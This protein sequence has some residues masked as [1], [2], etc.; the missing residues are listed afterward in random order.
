MDHTKNLSVPPHYHAEL[1]VVIPSRMRG[2][3]YIEQKSYPLEKSGLFLVRPNEVHS[4][5]YEP[6]RGNGSILVLQFDPF[7]LIDGI[8]PLSDAGLK[9]GVANLPALVTKNTEIIRETIL[10]LGAFRES[11]SAVS[12][13][14]PS[15]LLR[16]AGILCR[17]LHLLMSG[18]DGETKARHDDR[19]KRIIDFI[20]VSLSREFNL[21]DVARDACVTK[22]Y[23]CRYFKAKTG[24]T[25]QT[26][27]NRSRV[28]LAQRNMLEKGMNVTEAAQAGGFSSS[29]YFIQVFSRLQGISPKRWV[30]RQTEER[31][32]P[33][34]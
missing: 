17:I 25:L 2:R 16:D 5:R 20:Q 27:I 28:N 4:Y 9:G 23:L 34:H 12:P 31:R 30:L 24:L 33:E 1:E 21:D 22:A 15:T 6:V 18:Q 11:D 14:D 19:L 3:A 7:Q 32:N 29:A 13:P 8:R 26:Y 10:E